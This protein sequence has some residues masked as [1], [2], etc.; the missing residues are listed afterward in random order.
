[1]ADEPVRLQ[2]KCKNEEC[3]KSFTFTPQGTTD[4]SV[5]F[6]SF[7]AAMEAWGELRKAERSKKV[8][9]RFVPCPACK[10]AYNYTTDDMFIAV[11]ASSTQFGKTSIIPF[12]PT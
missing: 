7:N 9:G 4:E 8:F 1:M 5:T 3:G 12:P 6:E 10:R 2:A 11:P